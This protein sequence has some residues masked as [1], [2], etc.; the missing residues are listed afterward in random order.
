MSNDPRPSANSERGIAL[1]VVLLLLAAM[2]GLVTGMAMN[3][4][5]ES[6]MAMNETYYAGARAAAEAG[7]NRAIE[8]VVNNNDT[9]FLAG[10]DGVWDA[11]DPAAAVNADNGSL[12]FLLG[13][14]GPYALG[15][16]GQ[17]SYTIQVLDDDDP[18]L[19]QTA[20]T[21]AQLTAMG[22][23][24]GDLFVNEN[25]LLILRATG[26]GPNGTTV[27]LSRVLDNDSNVTEETTM[28][29]NPAIL[30]NGDLDISGNISVDGDNGNVHANGDM[31]ISGNSADVEGDAT[32][33]GT[34][35]ANAGWHAGGMQGGGQATVNAPDVNAADYIQ[36]ATHI[37]NANGTMTTV[38]TGATTACPCNNWSFSGGTWSIT[39]NTATAGT[40]YVNGAATISG[41]PG[42]S[43]SPVQLSVIATGSISVT[44]NPYLRPQNSAFLQFVTDGDLKLAG[45]VDVDVTTVE[46]QSL[47]REQLQI[48]GNPDIR[49]QIIVQDVE[50]VSD[51]VT[52]NVI[53][54]NPSITYNGSFG[55]IETITPGA[56]VYTNNVFGW[57]ESQ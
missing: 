44:G 52:S 55:D 28:L 6:A 32:A 57:L 15:A 5:I 38:A 8:A 46:G 1:I 18:A 27:T 54:G 51:L 45:N 22:E 33:T 48:S 34:F 2:S 16:T 53:S 31:V 12:T 42:S 11:A 30:V 14:A 37:L 40:Y 17:Y 24:T 49:G 3:G 19:Y 23:P 20:L 43:K 7:M 39:G 50:S 4:N 29:S 13:G 47:V 9:N 36:Y 56:T 21:A 41:S 35:T 10:T 26:I 25:D